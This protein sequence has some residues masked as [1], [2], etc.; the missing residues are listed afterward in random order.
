MIP[1]ALASIPLWFL[2][3]Y[4][5]AVVIVFVTGAGYFASFILPMVYARCPYRTGFSEILRTFWA[6]RVAPDLYRQ[7]QSYLCVPS[8]I[9]A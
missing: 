4:L 2:S 8:N 9:T 6:S 5:V 3:A 1:G 7:M